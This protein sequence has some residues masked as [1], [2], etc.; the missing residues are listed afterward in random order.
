MSQITGS[1][2][3]LSV[4]SVQALRTSTNKYHITDLLLDFEDGAQCTLVVWIILQLA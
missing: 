2:Y 3:H 1:V 4:N